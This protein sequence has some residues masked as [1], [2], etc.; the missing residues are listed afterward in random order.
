MFIFWPS[1]LPA[2]ITL[3]ILAGIVLTATIVA[4]RKRRKG[5]RVFAFGA[6]IAIVVFIPCCIVVQKFTDPYQLGVFV[7]QDYHDVRC[8]FAR[9]F[10]PETATDITVDQQINRHVAKFVISKPQVEAWLDQQWATRGKQSIKPRASKNE[11]RELGPEWWVERARELGWQVPS[12]L[13]AYD[14]PFWQSGASAT[15]FF[16][17][18]E[19]F[20]YQVAYYW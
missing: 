20:A 16:S 1:M 7:H 12:D 19:G 10:L 11:H 17:E 3:A 13:V 2:K 4:Q 8:D 9:I 15:I 6:F 18:S 14:G 5:T